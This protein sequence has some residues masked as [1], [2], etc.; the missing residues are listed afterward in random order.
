L[1]SLLIPVIILSSG[2]FFSIISFTSLSLGSVVELLLMF[3]WE[4][5]GFPIFLTFLSWDFQYNV[6][7]FVYFLTWEPWACLNR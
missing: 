5:V 6:M 7:I 2:F 1:I 3:W 4:C